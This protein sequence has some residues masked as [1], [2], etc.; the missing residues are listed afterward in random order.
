[1]LTWVSHINCGS[2]SNHYFFCPY[3]SYYKMPLSPLPPHQSLYW[4]IDNQFLFLHAIVTNINIILKN[5]RMQHFF[6]KFKFIWRTGGN[7]KLTLSIGS[8]GS[9]VW[10]GKFIQLGLMLFIRRD[11]FIRMGLKT[12]WSLSRCL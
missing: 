10:V 3:A 9:C 8:L 11:A 6:N 12:L 5:L 1:M 4:I 2:S 7:E